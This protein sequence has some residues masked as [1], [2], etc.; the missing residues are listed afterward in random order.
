MTN[1]RQIPV[2]LSRKRMV[3]FSCAVME[4]GSDGWLTT[5]LISSLPAKEDKQLILIESVLSIQWFIFIFNLSLNGRYY[6]RWKI[7]CYKLGGGFRTYHPWSVSLAQWCSALCWGR[8]AASHH[9]QMTPRPG[10]GQWPRR[11]RR[12]VFHALGEDDR[13]WSR[14]AWTQY[15]A[16][17]QIYTLNKD[18][19]LSPYWRQTGRELSSE[20]PRYEW[21]HRL[22]TRQDDGGLPSK[23][24]PTHCPRG[25]PVHCSRC[26]DLDGQTQIFKK[27]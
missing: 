25:R 2:L 14:G 15:K 8:T 4:T 12:W 24:D 7:N 13:W 19:Y 22:S 23:W 3:R 16:Q 27:P 6:L 26:Q 21:C 17:K 18:V 9:R 20:G 5:R 1:K 11:P 10:W